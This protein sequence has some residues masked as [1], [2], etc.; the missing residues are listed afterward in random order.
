MYALRQDSVLWEKFKG[1]V[2]LYTKE[3]I[4][5]ETGT[6][7]QEA[8]HNHGYSLKGKALKAEKLM[9]KR[10]D[11]SAMA[12]MSMEGIISLQLV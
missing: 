6:N 9:V 5:D 10:E 7:S 2:C 3:S 8:M 11:F 12:A 1:D 4:V